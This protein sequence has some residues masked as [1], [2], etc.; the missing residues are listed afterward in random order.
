M[1]YLVFSCLV[2]F[3]S[4][5]AFPQESDTLQNSERIFVEM[6]ANIST[7]NSLS[8]SVEKE[9]TYGRWKFGLE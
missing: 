3:S 9:F 4:L 6:S 1:K 2:L 5:F 8:I 7:Y